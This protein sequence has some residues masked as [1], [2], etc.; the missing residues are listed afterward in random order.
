MIV[1]A[2]VRFWTTERALDAH[3]VQF[4]D[5]K[6]AFILEC[7]HASELLWAVNFCCIL[8]KSLGLLL[9]W[10]GKTN[11]IKHM[12]HAAA[13]PESSG[14]IVVDTDKTR[15][16]KSV[17]MNSG[18][19]RFLA[20]APSMGLY[21]TRSFASGG[22]VYRVCQNN[23]SC[24]IEK[25]QSNALLC[26]SFNPQNHGSIDLPSGIPVS[27]ALV[28]FIRVWR[29]VLRVSEKQSILCGEKW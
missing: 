9:P 24:A 5:I 3:T 22:R 11:F 27:L 7:M 12:C 28:W 10:C 20:P 19:Q 6:I 13:V 8:W 26:S 21:V 14:A 23:Q 15:I 17:L 1:Y 29:G 16:N 2:D 18:N 25:L 4:E